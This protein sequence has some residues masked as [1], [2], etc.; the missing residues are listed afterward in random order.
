MK[1]KL[2]IYFFMFIVLIFLI[3][4]RNKIRKQARD[5]RYKIKEIS[6]HEQELEE[7]IP[8]IEKI[9]CYYEESITIH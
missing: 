5:L 6:S 3:L 1:K 4:S 2:F 9:E 8:E 7:I